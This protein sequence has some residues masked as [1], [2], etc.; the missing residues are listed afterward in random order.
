[1][2]PV[3]RARATEYLDVPIHYARPLG[4]SG[5]DAPIVKTYAQ[6][7]WHSDELPPFVTDSD[8]A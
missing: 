3:N 6:L 7:V 8:E 1:M 4:D 2:T 5:A